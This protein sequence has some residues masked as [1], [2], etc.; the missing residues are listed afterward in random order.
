MEILLLLHVL[1]LFYF[2]FSFAFEDLSTYGDS[3]SVSLVCLLFYFCFIYLFCA[4]EHQVER[5]NILIL[6][7]DP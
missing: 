5:L 6:I 1:S 2:L 7:A 3:H 4:Y